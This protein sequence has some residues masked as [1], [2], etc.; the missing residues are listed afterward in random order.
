MA[1]MA[2]S[3]RSGDD[4]L[5]IEL[6]PV[7]NAETPPIPPT[8]VM[9]EAARQ[10][11]ELIDRQA[12]RRRMP[13]RDFLRT[14]MATAAVLFTLDSVNAAAGASGGRFRLPEDASVDPDVARAMLGGD[15][16]VMDV[17]THFLDL[18][19]AEGVPAFP[20]SSCGESDPR[21]C[22][23]VD[24]YLEEI[25]LRSDTNIAV[26]SAVP[27]VDLDGPLSPPRMDEARRAADA[28]CGDGRV[29]MHG[30]SQP[31]IG[32]LD[33]RLD[34][35]NMLVDR[36]P[37]S[38]WK[39]YTHTPGRGWFLDD[40]EPDAPQVGQAFLD[41]ARETGVT[42]VSVHKGLSN[43]DPY[44]SPV[45]IGPAAKANPDLKF[46]VYHSGYEN[47]FSEGP[48][49]PAGEGVDRLI[50]SLRANDIGPNEN[51]YAELGST[52][53]LTMRNPEEAAHVLGKLLKA[54]GPK[55]IVWG[56]DSLWYGTPQNQIEAFRTFEISPELQDRY[57]Y[58]ALTK[59][60]K[61]RILGLN[62]ARLYGVDPIRSRCDFTPAEL[63]D[64]RQALPARPAS[65]G[66]KTYAAVRAHV[67][68]HG[69]I[70]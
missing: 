42:T 67:E 35:M 10:A 60:T 50:E 63:E 57:G 2:R 11:K 58:P 38:S 49:N 27:G 8:P 52:W 70:G 36:Y 21:L 45:D 54:V 48:A 47:A 31:Q 5:P 4:E 7:S 9:R 39:L 18:E 29:L 20:Q 66:P 55:R 14:T 13:R 33:D 59:A 6:G 69:W 53:F 25:F 56:T 37:I 15:E 32:N 61:R 28:L 17:Q 26:L 34:E 12:R 3:D 19:P 23:S 43:G 51:V 30:Q 44:S 24:K 40:H 1:A 41:R 16:F 64:V 62:A 22:Y 46:V 68:E 65:Y